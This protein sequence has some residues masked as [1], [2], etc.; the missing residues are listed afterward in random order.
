RKLRK[1]L[2]RCYVMMT[3]CN[4]TSLEASMKES[5]TAFAECLFVHPNV[6]KHPTTILT[7]TRPQRW[8]KRRISRYVLAI[9]MCRTLYETLILIDHPTMVLVLRTRIRRRKG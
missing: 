7:R 5:A 1:R 8:A 9:N 2:L 3:A 4:S 6:S